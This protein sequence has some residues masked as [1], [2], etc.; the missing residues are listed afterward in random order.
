[1]QQIFHSFGYLRKLES[2]LSQFGGKIGGFAGCNCPKSRKSRLKNLESDEQDCCTEE[3][4]RL[5]QE[6][7]VSATVGFTVSPRSNFRALF[8][9]ISDSTVM[10][11]T[12]PLFYWTRP[13]GCSHL[14]EQDSVDQ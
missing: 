5:H 4:H 13:S 3:R 2:I 12:V 11:H 10:N 14:L 1:M 7:E 8:S 9:T 6:F